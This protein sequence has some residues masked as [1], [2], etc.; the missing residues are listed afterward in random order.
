MQTSWIALEPVFASADI[1]KQL[2]NEAKIFKEVDNQ[3]HRVMEETHKEALVTAR[4]RLEGLHET[5]K[6]CHEKLEIV[7]RELNNYLEK[8]RQFFPRFYFLSNDELLSIL[9]ETKDPSKV[10]PHLKKCF[11][12]I[13]SLTFDEEHK[14]SAMVSPEGEIVEFIRIIDPA[15]AEGAVERW[16]IEVE[17][18]MI[19]S[20]RDIIVKA[21]ADYP[22]KERKDWVSGHRGQ[23][24][25]CAS[26]TYWT[27]GAE[28]KMLTGGTKGLEEYSIQCSRLLT[29]VVDLVRGRI[30][31]LLRCTLKALIVLD[32]HCRDVIDALITD[33]IED[34]NDFN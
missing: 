33:G 7:Q 2:Y 4:T 25:L 28:D 9:K 15:L 20:T 23:A 26:M 32:V 27:R 22:K 34:K 31:E 14:I 18:C 6:Y 10:Q 24:V 11:E 21:I 30:P 19:K 12:G 29:D 5:L 3:W 17:D 13:K 8:K 16:L 1:Q